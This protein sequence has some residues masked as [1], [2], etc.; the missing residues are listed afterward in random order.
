MAVKNS[1]ILWVISLLITVCFVSL[2]T[3]AKY[4][5]GKE[6][7]GVWTIDEGNDY[8]RLWWENA[9]RH[10]IETTRQA[11]EQNCTPYILAIVLTM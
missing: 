3:H 2:P 6:S 7:V 1:Q 8:P 4:G 10:L 5:G 9:P 11:S